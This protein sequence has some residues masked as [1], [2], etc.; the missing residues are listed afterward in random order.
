MFFTRMIKSVMRVVGLLGFICCFFGGVS[1][2]ADYVNPEG[3]TI[4][5]NNGEAALDVYGTENSTITNKGTIIVKGQW[6]NAPWYA[7]AIHAQSSALDID[8]VI[9]NEGKIQ[10]TATNN[11]GNIAAY[12]LSASIAKS[13][14]G[15]TFLN[16]GSIGFNLKT[17]AGHSASM[18]VMGIV[19]DSE[20]GHTLTNSGTITGSVEGGSAHVNALSASEENPAGTFPY[21][22]NHVFTNE[23]RGVID[24]TA[25]ATANNGTAVASAFYNQLDANPTFTNSGTI[26]VTATSQGSAEAYG[27]NSPSINIIAFT[28]SGDRTMINDEGATMDISAHGVG[29]TVAAGFFTNT[30]GGH[31]FTNAGE[32]TVNAVS[33]G[34]SADALAYG[35]YHSNI[36]NTWDFDINM[37]NSGN[38]TVNASNSTS[39]NVGAYGMYLDAG[40]F[41]KHIII[42]SGNVNVS[43]IGNNNVEARGIHNHRSGPETHT[44]NSGTVTVKA[45]GN[46]DALASGIS[47]TNVLNDSTGVINVSATSSTG[48]ATAYGI[49]I[50]SGTVNNLGII[51]VSA[52]GNTSR[53]YE[54]YGSADYS[55]GKYATTLRDFSN[56]KIFGG[57]GS[58]NI[59]FDGST[60]ILRPGIEGQGF[61]YGKQYAIKDMTDNVT[62]LGSVGSVQAE[63]SLL[64]ARL[65]GDDANNQKVSLSTNVTAATN[66]GHHLVSKM[67]QV[68]KARLSNISAGL[69]GKMRRTMIANNNIVLQEQGVSGGSNMMQALNTTQHT[70]WS[71]FLAPHGGTTSNNNIDFHG[72]TA[73]VF[74]GVTYNFNESFAMGV[75]MDISA[76][77]FDGDHMNMQAHSLAL[78]AGVHASY[79][80][81]PEWYAQA[82]FTSSFADNNVSLREDGFSDLS[83]DARYASNA[84]LADVSTGYMIKLGENHIIT[85]EIGAS[86]LNI[87]TQAYDLIWQDQTYN[88]HVEDNIYNAFYATAMLNYDG[89]FDLGEQGSVKL[90]AGIGVRQNLSGFD[91]ESKLRFVGEK[92]T[93]RSTEDPTTILANAGV[94]WQKDNFSVA[95]NYTG[96]YGNTQNNHGGMLELKFDF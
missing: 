39:D 55:I 61:E 8:Y 76:S 91:L 89:L 2:A 18:D 46:G 64:A 29:H 93:T 70:P 86:W 68:N 63:S 5:K 12:A 43:A 24:I 79:I 94:S 36:R 32:M 25:K 77:K 23:V 9:S 51:N 78:S 26:K 6:P 58:N 15:S 28:G 54:V 73:G 20:L 4:T 48:L 34:A 30:Q 69:A 11:V 19:A 42:N 92:F 3:K 22:P 81:T 49:N 50:V 60:L 27:V 59:N 80:I 71:V 44:S 52:S 62:A 21:T 35:F 37:K 47:G 7:R 90:S 16:S 57:A 84:L 38:L 88:M 40:A 82:S 85:P 56:Y 10:M 33:T 14:G 74:G 41:D 65:E 83:A 66:P 31:K 96:A 75:H 17:P 95:L 45:T 1:L 53:A 72:N 13:E 67:V 87:Y